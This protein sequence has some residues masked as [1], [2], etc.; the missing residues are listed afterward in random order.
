[1]AE[2]L[3]TEHP[4]L[5]DAIQSEW[6]YDRDVSFV[7]ETLD[8]Y[9]I[10]ADQMLEVGCGTGE[11][12]CRF[13]RAGLD[14]TGI[15]KYDG[16]LDLARSKCDADF[17]KASLPDTSAPGMYDVVVAIRGVIN[18][19]QPD[20][21]APTI[22]TLADRLR[23]NGLLIFDNSPLPTEGNEP[24]LDVGTTREGQ[25]VRVAHH[26]PT[27]SGTLEWRAVTYTPTGECFVNSREMT[28]FDDATIGATLETSGLGFEIHEGYGT[29]DSRTVFV[30]SRN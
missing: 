12:T 23:N 8:R 1:M 18:H 17:H 3:Y 26:V 14:V 25:Y 20:A 22:E 2:H 6:D 21:L 11:H 29:G 28:P 30:A 10:A 15:D 13:K 16:M 19:L 4:A 27:G 9:G 7:L 5:Y 24:A